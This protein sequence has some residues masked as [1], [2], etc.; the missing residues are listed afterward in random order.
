MSAHSVTILI[1][2]ANNSNAYKVRG[3]L[4]QALDYAR[5]MDWPQVNSEEWGNLRTI[6]RDDNGDDTA[7]HNAILAALH[8]QLVKWEALGKPSNTE[9][10]SNLRTIARDDNGDDTALHNAILA[11]LHVQLVKWEA[12]GKPSNTEEWREAYTKAAL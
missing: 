7:L 9:E 3:D 5:G 11:A 12:L 1:Q 6:A 8:V 4:L 2:L 10:W